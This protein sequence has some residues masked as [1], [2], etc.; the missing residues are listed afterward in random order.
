M[1]AG[2]VKALLRAI[3]DF[4]E[5]YGDD[6]RYADLLPKLGEVS[7]E[8]KSGQPAQEESPG[9]RAAAEAAVG[10]EA[11]ER[12]ALSPAQDEEGEA[13]KAPPRNFGEA[14]E[15]ARNRFP[16]GEKPGDEGT[17]DE[18]SKRRRLKK[19]EGQPA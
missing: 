11:P 10:E 14:R 7:E 17:D 15:R 19:K 4:E 6:P 16:S 1:P 8:V 3:E 12:K 9:K 5:A 2:E 18:E 13:D